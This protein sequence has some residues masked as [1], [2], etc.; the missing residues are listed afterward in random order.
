MTQHPLIRVLLGVSASALLCIHTATAQVYK[1]TDEQGRVI[2]TD[3]PSGSAEAVEVAP[4]NTAAPIAEREREPEAAPTP[5]S[6]AYQSLAIVSP[7]DG[8]IIPSRA[9]NFDVRAALVP[10]LQEGHQ[11]ALTINGEPY[12]N[13]A[14]GLFAVTSL[15]RGNHQ[16]Q[17]KVVDQQGKTVIA[18]STVSVQVYRPST[19]GSKRRKPVTT[20]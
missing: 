1:E 17:V 8:S 4:V 9:G 3:K 16:L 14:S 20:Q 11:L 12:G 15:P 13:G 2:F 19:A 7:A 10:A 18:S 5:E 6:D